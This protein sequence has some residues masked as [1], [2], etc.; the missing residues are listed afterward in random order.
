MTKQKKGNA[1]VVNCASHAEYRVT[2]H[3]QVDRKKV[4]HPV[5]GIAYGKPNTKLEVKAADRTFIPDGE[6]DLY[7][8]DTEDVMRV[9]N[10]QGQWTLE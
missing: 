7:P 3:L 9:R 1:K 2:F 8:D 5:A 10:A 6:Y 4:S